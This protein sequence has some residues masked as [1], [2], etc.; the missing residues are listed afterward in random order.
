MSPFPLFEHEMFNGVKSV[1]QP[2]LVCVKTGPNTHPETGGPG[3]CICV[4]ARGRRWTGPAA[5][6][7]KAGADCERTRAGE[8]VRA[9]G[10]RSARAQPSW[11]GATPPR[12]TPSPGWSRHPWTKS[13]SR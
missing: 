2:R 11:A 10:P 9:A 3:I 13:E 6:S 4:K 8:P 1:T 5:D 12:R 7:R